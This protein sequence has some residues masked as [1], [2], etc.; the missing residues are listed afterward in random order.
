M[1]NFDTP[2]DGWFT[3][4][5]WNVDLSTRGPFVKASKRR[6]DYEHRLVNLAKQLRD[7]GA[8]TAHALGVTVIVPVKGGPQYDLA[9]LV[10]AAEPMRD[11]LI[12]RTGD[13]GF[14][15][16][17]LAM[18]A[19]NGGRFGD[20]EGQDGEILLNHF[21]GETNSEN[22]VEAWKSI[23][24]WYARA[25]KVDNSTLLEFT[26]DAPFLIVNYAVLPGK[27]V[28]FL[29]GQLLR[30]S[31]YSVVRKQLHDVVIEPFPL[32]ARRLGA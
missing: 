20:T 28:P 26:P 31:F 24:E 21:A 23:S 15:E 32:I 13:L 17:E 11:D 1:M 16:P 22:A 9:L 12:E 18:T 6:G 14:P 30:P 8:T 5:A 4:L 29:A 3:H 10:H 19:R 25:L 2:L 27:T 7:E